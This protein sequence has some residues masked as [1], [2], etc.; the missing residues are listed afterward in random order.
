MGHEQMDLRK[1]NDP[2]GIRESYDEDIQQG[3]STFEASLK[4]IDPKALEKEEMEE[5]A[6]IEKGLN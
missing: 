6:S 3:A 5:R 4:K 2:L 1:K